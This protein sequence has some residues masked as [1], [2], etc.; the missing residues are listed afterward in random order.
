MEK[1][2]QL[3]LPC[4]GITL[5]RFSGII[6]DSRLK[7]S[8]NTPGTLKSS[9]FLVLEPGFGTPVWEFY[10]NWGKIKGKKLSEGVTF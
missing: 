10:K 7:L 9:H 6:S 5:I 8:G 2:R 3:L 4:A 1:G